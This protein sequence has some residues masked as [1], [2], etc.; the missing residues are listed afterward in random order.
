MR[1]ISRVARTDSK[2][3]RVSSRDLIDKELP[4]LAS[5]AF[6]LAGWPLAA[7]NVPTNQASF[8][9]AS[10]HSVS[11]NQASHKQAGLA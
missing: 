3:S 5:D 4:H 7:P 1:L 9:Q 10:S 11:A 8:K 6:V 2:T